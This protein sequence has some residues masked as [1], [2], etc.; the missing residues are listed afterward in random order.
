MIQLRLGGVPEHF[1]LPWLRLLESAELGLLGIQAEWR[2]VPEGSGAM[3]AALRAG[4]LDVAM[5]LT[6]GAVAGV[7]NGGGFKIVSLYTESPLLWGIHVPA[8]SAL[9][10]VADIRGARYAISRRGSGSHLMA[11]V[12]AREQGWPADALDLV[13]VGNLE[14][15]VDAFATGTADVFFW[16]KFMTKPL[17]DAGRFRRVGEFAA[18][19][20]AFVVCASAAAIAAHGAAIALLV[21][22]ALSAAAELAASKDAAAVIAA[23]YGLEREDVVQWLAVTRWAARVGIES[24]TLDPAIEGLRAVG[25]VPRDLDAAA[26]MHRLPPAA[27][28]M[29][30]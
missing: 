25:L 12:H 26:V 24:R 13:V 7:A 15:A 19:W 3:A 10:G 1:N 5:L 30:R 14:G 18:P 11:A 28:P 6:E 23:R 21:E 17:V 29:S 16:E 20:P 4:E 22:R 8:A 9:A 2:D 27:G